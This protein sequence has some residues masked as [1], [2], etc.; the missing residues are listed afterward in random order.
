MDNLLNFI[1]ELPVAD[2][3]EYV[4]DKTADT[5]SFLFDPIKASSQTLIDL[6]TSTLT[7]IPAVILIALVALLAFFASGKKFGLAIFSVVGLWFIHNHVLCVMRVPDLD[8]ALRLVNEHEY[9]NGTAGFTRD[10]GAAREFAHRVQAGMVGIN[11][12]IP[13]P[14]AFHSFGGWK[15]SIFGPLHVHGPDGVR[16]YTR[17]KTVTAR[18]PDTHAAE[19]VMPTMK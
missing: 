18:W 14:M 4:T 2:F 3:A 19:F 1:P 11:V 12:P 7:A 17:L 5:F 6:M 16:F 9:G 13:V 10:G 8:A 15:R